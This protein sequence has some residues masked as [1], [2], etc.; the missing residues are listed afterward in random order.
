M[1]ILDAD[2]KR[3]ALQNMEA[4]RDEILSKLG[5]MEQ[6]IREVAGENYLIWERAR[7][8]WYTSI[9][10]NLSADAGDFLGSMVNF[11]DTL[12]ELREQIIDEESQDQSDEERE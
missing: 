10:N 4:L 6:I 8:Y 2:D 3:L 1:I 12:S 9:E 5:E 7:S 11:S